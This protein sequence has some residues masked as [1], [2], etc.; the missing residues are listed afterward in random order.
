MKR[1]TDF[2]TQKEDKS[3]AEVAEENPNLFGCSFCAFCVTFAS[4]AFG[5]P[6]PH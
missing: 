4:S 1:N 3:D 2:R 6:F 5:C